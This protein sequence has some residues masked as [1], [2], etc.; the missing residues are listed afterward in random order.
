MSLL[1]SVLY[2]FVSGIT[3]FLPVS[4]RA[5]QALL[6]YILGVQTRDSMQNLLVHIGVF[7]A[8]I[9][10]SREYLSRLHREQKAISGSRRRRV[11]SSDAKSLYDLR[12][13]KT[14]TFP[15]VIGLLL[16]FPMGK[17]ENSLLFI[18][19]FLIFNGFVLLLA[20]HCSHGNRDSRTMT[21]LDGIVMG[22]VGALSS[23]PGISRTG[24]ITAYAT[25][26]GA[27]SQN[28]TNWAV[29]L[30]IPALIFAACYDIVGIA[31]SSIGVITFP[32]IMG[33]LLSGAAAFAGGYLGIS[34]LRAVLNH[35][36]FS[37]FAYYSLGEALLF[38]ILYLIT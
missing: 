5:H 30:G 14:A 7:F 21:G 33:N 24:M 38:F 32:I 23:F 1:E 12:L 20:E 11:R 34:A 26:R 6:R 25:V 19:I 10:S 16:S 18:I 4:P 31:T 28:A 8:I 2:G 9:L 29:L 22:I 27:D 3:E 17:L 13:L 36:G 35:S 15:L 37:S